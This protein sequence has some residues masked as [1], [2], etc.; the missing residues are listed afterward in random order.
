MQ[1]SQD[2][3]PKE[4]PKLPNKQQTSRTG[5]LEVRAHKTQVLYCHQASRIPNPTLRDGF[6]WRT[7]RSIARRW[8]CHSLRAR[9]LSR[10]ASS[11]K[12]QRAI[13]VSGLRTS[14]EQ[15]E[16]PTVPLSSTTTRRKEMVKLTA[17]RFGST[18]AAILQP[19]WIFSYPGWIRCRVKP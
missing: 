5:P 6:G 3:L 13:R 8:R 11:V 12:G 7:H 15:Q 4:K 18:I 17:G 16:L 1:S 9:P 19:I 2:K 10:M 14:K